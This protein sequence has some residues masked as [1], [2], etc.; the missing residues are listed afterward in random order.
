MKWDEFDAMK[1]AAANAKLKEKALQVSRLD[2]GRMGDGLVIIVL[3]KTLGKGS[4]R[5][6]NGPYYYPETID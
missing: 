5:R 2:K 3:P 4:V 6:N 1:K